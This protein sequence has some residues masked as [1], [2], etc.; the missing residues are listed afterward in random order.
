MEKS[1]MANFTAA[2]P[3][4]SIGGSEE[5]F[6]AIKRFRMSARCVAFHSPQAHQREERVFLKPAFTALGLKSVHEV[7]N[8]LFARL[9][10]ERHKYV[11]LSHIAVVFWDFVFEYQMIAES[12]PS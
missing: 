8:F 6:P 11:G 4:G 2:L 12:I 9:S 3:R 7:T 1:E 10:I 5:H